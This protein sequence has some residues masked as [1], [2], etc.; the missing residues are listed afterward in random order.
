MERT[1]RA[2]W[3]TFSEFVL[4][5]SPLSSR[6]RHN[7][8][9]PANRLPTEV[10]CHIF[11]VL[12]FDWAVGDSNSEYGDSSSPRAL[13]WVTVSHVCHR[14]REC[15]IGNSLLWSNPTG[16]NNSKWIDE[17]LR[18]ARTAPLSI[19]RQP[20]PPYDVASFCV[21]AR[22]RISDHIPSHYSR[23]ESLCLRGS[24]RELQR[25]FDACVTHPSLLRELV[26][27]CN[28]SSHTLDD[29]QSSSS[30]ILTLPEHISR[31]NA[32]P[33]LQHLDLHMV[34]V[35]WASPL[36]GSNLRRLSII[37]PI[38]S[39][40][41]TD[42]QSW[43]VEIDEC[44]DAL[45]NMS[46]LEDL[47]LH[48]V[49]PAA[50]RLQAP[51]FPIHMPQLE[52][53]D[54]RGSIA[55]CAAVICPLDCPSIRHLQV[56]VLNAFP[57][58]GDV[59]TLFAMLAENLATVSFTRT[60]CQFRFS[61][62]DQI[63]SFSDIPL[64]S[65]TRSSFTLIL[66]ARGPWL[67]QDTITTFSQFFQTIRLPTLRRLHLFNI[68]PLITSQH[69]ANAFQHM[70]RLKSLHFHDTAPAVF[71]NTLLNVDGPNGP[72]LFSELDNIHFHSIT[73]GLPTELGHDRVISSTG[74]LDGVRYL[75]VLATALEMRYRRGF[76]TKQVTFGR[77]CITKTAMVA[78]EKLHG[79]ALWVDASSSTAIVRRK[80]TQTPFL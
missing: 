23:I 78:L 16:W 79:I 28:G 12:S 21:E 11:L 42:A 46:S 75:D 71:P 41:L 36:F 24:A 13:G 14:W 1:R 15:A 9:S 43:S 20:I 47:T 38:A 55:S 66:A 8:C 63:I 44:L 34:A 48:H 57:D 68:P 4:G 22:A 27:Y 51:R 54:F 26:V 19:H 76:T 62:K 40:H 52:Q 30:T 59:G 77:C 32:S 10:L 56:I 64:Q 61:A 74:P 67:E 17:M 31:T 37:S 73:F 49:F 6:R 80:S 70:R 7:E 69:W 5:D 33:H 53:I 35:P 58:G 50:N 3:R 60:L 18:R 29:M 45:S 72:A 25:V 65:G 2:L 39:T